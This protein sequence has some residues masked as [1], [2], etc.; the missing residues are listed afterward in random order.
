[1][2][3]TAESASSASEISFYVLGELVVGYM[4]GLSHR[5][6]DTTMDTRHPLKTDKS[7]FVE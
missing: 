6:V 5:S 3:D 7:F 4:Y 2:L 1:M